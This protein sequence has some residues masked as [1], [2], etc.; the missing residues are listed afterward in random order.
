M[1]TGSH[2]IPVT[3]KTEVG[4]S[5]VPGQPHKGGKIL[6]QKKGGELTANMAQVAQHVASILKAPGSIP[7]TAKKKKINIY[8]CVFL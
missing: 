5:Q 6:S 1:Y 7:S 2:V 8:S 3:T 4:G